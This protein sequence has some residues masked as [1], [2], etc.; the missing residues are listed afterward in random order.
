M[1]AKMLFYC[2]QIL[3]GLTFFMESRLVWKG[4]IQFQ[5]LSGA[6]YLPLDQA[7]QPLPVPDHL[8]GFFDGFL[9]V[10][11]CSGDTGHF[12]HTGSHLALGT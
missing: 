11:L 12:P 2:I 9:F 10:F 8:L 5:P 1:L 4:L 3:Q 7:V 6:R